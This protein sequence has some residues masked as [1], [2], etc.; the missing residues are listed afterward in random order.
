MERTQELPELWAT[1]VLERR[2]GI[3]RD[4]FNRIK[5][6]QLVMSLSK[7]ISPIVSTKANILSRGMA[8]PSRRPMHASDLLT[9]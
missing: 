4:F 3:Q 9:R 6:A 1:P 5:G 8:E 2:N 7:R